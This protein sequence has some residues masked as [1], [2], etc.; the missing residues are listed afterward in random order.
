MEISAVFTATVKHAAKIH[1]VETFVSICCCV[2][3]AP[4][5]IFAS[6]KGYLNFS[7]Q[8]SY[9]QAIVK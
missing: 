2:G 9:I 5:G 1:K 6:L 7:V 3:L 4:A 8:N